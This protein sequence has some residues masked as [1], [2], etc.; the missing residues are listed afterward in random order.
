M[1]FSAVDLEELW[2]NFVAWLGLLDF[3][4]VWTATVERSLHSAHLGRL[5]LHAFVH[6]VK[7]VDWTSTEKM[8]FMDALPNAS[9]TKARGDNLK[10]VR[11]QGHFYCWAWK[12]G[13]VKVQTSGYEPWR[14][15][16]VKGF[17]IDQ[18]W[19][20]HKLSHDVYIQY[21]E[22]IRVGFMTRLK[23]VE[24]IKARETERA[25][26]EKR[27]VIATRLAPLQKGFKP[28]VLELLRPWAEQYKDMNTR[29]KF[30]VLRGASRTGKS[31][32]AKSLGA[33]FGFGG[34]PFVQTVQ[35]ALDPDLR[36]YDSDWHSYIVFDNVNDMRFVLDQ[37]A[38]F[39]S[40]N[41]LH[42][43]GESKT[44]LYSYTVGLFQ[45]PLVVTVDMS[46]KWDKNEPRLNVNCWR[47]PWP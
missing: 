9:P 4:R 26:M 22:R 39:Q 30:L 37:R 5:H 11:D 20:E 27:S 8:R 25:L 36:N 16:A 14:D 23:Q 17:W 45:I 34:T 6:F 40:N 2:T 46:A 1:R 43:L 33:L 32:L 28:E 42:K 38:L 7:S 29:Y 15:Y 35:S 31:T 19:T 21:A 3:V 41:D 47:H 44:G 12:N 10:A 18:L 24:A 13:T